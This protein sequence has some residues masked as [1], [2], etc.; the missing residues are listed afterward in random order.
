MKRLVAPFLFMLITLSF[1]FGCQS[2]KEKTDVLINKYLLEKL[3]NYDSYSP[4]ELNF[5]EAYNIALN[6]SSCRTHAANI[7]KIRNTYDNM[8]QIF[9]HQLEEVG[10]FTKGQNIQAFDTRALERYPEIYTTNKMIE[11]LSATLDEEISLLK[12]SMPNDKEICIG[13]S[14]YHKFRYKDSTGNPA[15]GYY[16]FLFDKQVNNI[17]CVID[18][19]N[20]IN[21]EIV[22]VLNEFGSDDK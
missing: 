16:Y 13:Y 20:D 5:K 6:D 11:N 4:I 12:L 17:L 2:K 9:Q 18:L 10:L 1:C 22:D 7:V 19:N 14:V 3:Y 8:V 21:K 15:V